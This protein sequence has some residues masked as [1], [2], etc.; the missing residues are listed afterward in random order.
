V[1]VRRRLAG[2]RSAR[3]HTRGVSHARA[4]RSTHRALDVWLSTQSEVQ[5]ARARECRG[6]SPCREPHTSLTATCCNTDHRKRPGKCPAFVPSVSWRHRV[7]NSPFSLMS[8]VLQYDDNSFL[9]T[10]FLHCV[11]HSTQMLDITLLLPTGAPASG[12][13]GQSLTASS[14]TPCVLCSGLYCCVCAVARRIFRPK[15]LTNGSRTNGREFV[16]VRKD[17]RNMSCHG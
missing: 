15:L 4:P 14:M 7:E 6:A 5:N 13:L 2:I 16:I 17:C 9:E 8:I 12:R 3:R 1:R 10:P 11:P